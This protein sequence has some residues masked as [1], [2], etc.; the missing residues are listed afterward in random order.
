MAFKCLVEKNK[1]REKEGGPPPPHGSIHLPFLI[2]N[3]AKNTV[4]DCSISN[5]K[6]VIKNIIKTSVIYI[7]LKMLMLGFLILIFRMEYLF[8]FDGTFEIHDD[9]EVLK[10]MGLALGLDKGECTDED[11]AKAK[12]VLPKALEMYIDQIGRRDADWRADFGDDVDES[13]YHDGET[14]DENVCYEVSGASALSLS[15]LGTTGDLT[16]IS[17]SVEDLEMHAAIES[18]HNQSGQGMDGSDTPE[19]GDD[20]DGYC[21]DEDDE[22]GLGD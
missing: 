15:G 9:I 7:Q 4:I 19:N 3:T 16:G 22:D 14:A 8:N 6:Y 1:E 21:D 5:D 20:E 18:L 11:I 10:R 17:M 2:V 12:R 13:Y